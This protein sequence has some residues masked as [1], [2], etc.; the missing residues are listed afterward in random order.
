[1]TI[2]A[3]NAGSTS[4]KFGLFDAAREPLLAGAIDWS[5]GRRREAG[6]TLR[7]RHGP[8]QVSVVDA[9][10]DATATAL[11]LQW[12]AAARHGEAIAAV[13]HRVVH[14][15]TEFSRSVRVDAA[16]K[17]AIGRWGAL[18]PLHNPPALRVIEAAE[19]ALPGV[20]QVAVFDTAF[21][22]AL[23][24]SAVVYPVPFEWYEKWGIRRFGFHG[25]SHAYCAGRAPEFLGRDAARLRLVICH[26]GG[27][28]SAAAVCEGR[29]VASTMGFSPLE[30]L[31]MGTRCGSIDPGLLLH[32]QRQFGFT[33]AEMDQALNH[34]S[35]LLGISG[36]SADLAA[37]EAAAA[38]GNARARLAFDMFADRVRSAVGSLAAA[39]GGIDVLVFTD[40]VGEHSPALR[41]AVGH[42]L[43]FMGLHLDD[44][45]NRQARADIDIATA[46]S[47]VRIL[48]LHTREEL[49][50]AREAQQV[51]TGGL[52]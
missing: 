27:G 46:D 1:M 43:E 51:V 45:A 16:V 34:A 31:M 15:G 26:L 24:L 32:V 19:T 28:C 30:G 20:P 25:L 7:P 8:P 9:G 17:A 22:A 18:A 49:L 37:I 6:L 36:V 21:F 3:L 38:S 12:A 29:P 14:G 44:P 5:G 13:G 39:M 41:A 52:A 48:V 10:D 42:G 2:L 40:R 33:P 23:P 35:G 50:I 11:A 47:A 4:L